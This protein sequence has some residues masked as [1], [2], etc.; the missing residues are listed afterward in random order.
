MNTPWRADPLASLTR[1]LCNPP[2]SGEGDECPDIWELDNGDIAVVGQDLTGT[3]IGSRR[4]GELKI[5]QD[6]RL[7]VI[8]RST[9]LSA[10]AAI[11]DA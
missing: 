7:V 5:A 6:E 4:P 11:A 8:P 2:D 9:F 10:K 1:R 3:Y